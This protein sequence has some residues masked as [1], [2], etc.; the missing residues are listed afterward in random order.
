MEMAGLLTN[1]QF[2]TFLEDVVY[3]YQSG[4]ER[5]LTGFRTLPLKPAFDMTYAALMRNNNIQVMARHVALDAHAI[6]NPTRGAEALEGTIP[7][8]ATNITIGKEDYLREAQLLMNAELVGTSLTVAAQD[9]LAEKFDAKFA[10][11]NARASYM[12]DYVVFHGKYDIT[13]QNNAGSFYDVTFD[14]R[15]PKDNKVAL[16]GD[17]KWWTSGDFSTEGSAAD[18]MKDL[19]DIIAKAMRKG[20]KKTQLV[21][22]IGILTAQAL[23]RHTKVREAIA[24]FMNPSVAP[25]TEDQS[26]SL[27]ALT[28]GMSDEQLAA[29]LSARLGVEFLIRDFITSIPVFN[30]KKGVFEV[31]EQTGFEEGTIVCRPKGEIGEVHSTGHLMIGGSGDSVHSSGLYDGGRILMDYNCN[32]REKVQIWDTEEI[33]LYV[34]TQGKNMFYLTTI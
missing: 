6:P 21:I 19:D 26:P 20:F 12:R 17:S 27:A 3:P 11:H 10:E 1:E 9:M 13:A 7:A 32:L 24:V 15:V 33:S 22:E 8:V 29:Q 5:D 25:R 16:A 18:P 30:Q 34:L 4:A 31:N 2:S 14:F 23:C 28:Y